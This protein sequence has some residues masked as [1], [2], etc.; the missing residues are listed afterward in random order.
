MAW[1][2][3]FCMVLLR[4]QVQISGLGKVSLESKSQ[5]EIQ[6]QI[7][8]E[9]NKGNVCMG[10]LQRETMELNTRLSSTPKKIICQSP[11]GIAPGT[12][13]YNS[14]LTEFFRN[15]VSPAFPFANHFIK[16]NLF[17]GLS[18]CQPSRLPW[19]M[20]RWETP[21]KCFLSHRYLWVMQS[22]WFWWALL[23]WRSPPTK[24]IGWLWVSEAVVDH[25]VIYEVATVTAPLGLMIQLT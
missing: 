9:G 6:L 22:K 2:L 8:R 15:L 4:S 19:N 3:L 1:H 20:F 23:S 7:H 14:V 17:H 10:L 21:E 12:E 16:E 5:R 24:G 25:I 11:A 13:A 18:S